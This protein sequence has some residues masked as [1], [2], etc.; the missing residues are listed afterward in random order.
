VFW[1]CFLCFNL[2]CCRFISYR[3]IGF[4][5][6]I[7]AGMRKQGWHLI[8]KLGI[9]GF[10]FCH[11]EGCFHSAVKYVVHYPQFLC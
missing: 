1:C 6:L 4:M 2:G 10:N 11:R 5:R 9:F 7:L 8:M 3:L